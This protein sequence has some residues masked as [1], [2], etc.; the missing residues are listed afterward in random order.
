[1]FQTPS[2]FLS[3]AFKTVLDSPSPDELWMSPKTEKVLQNGS[4]TNTSQELEKSR[5]HG[6]IPPTTLLQASTIGHFPEKWVTYI[7]PIM[8]HLI[9]SIIL[10][11]TG[12]THLAIT[13]SSWYTQVLNLKESTRW[14]YQSSRTFF[15][16][17]P[18]V[19]GCVRGKPPPGREALYTW[20][21]IW[22]KISPSVIS[23]IIDVNWYSLVQKVP[24]ANAKS[25]WWPAS[26]IGCFW[27]PCT[28]W[29][30]LNTHV[31]CF[32]LN[33]FGHPVDCLTEAQSL[34]MFTSWRA[35]SSS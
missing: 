35:E 7:L 4:S 6:D 1:M 29:Q 11:F 8:V 31:Q 10:Y 3:L 23:Y 22:A 16:V 24:S 17:K 33:V 14:S 19:G 26:G 18:Q 12:S 15:V 9:Q 2:I 28:P 32:M 5:Q 25:S 34:M 13:A 30:R 20:I 27:K 21:K